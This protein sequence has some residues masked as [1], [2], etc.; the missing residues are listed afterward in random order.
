MKTYLPNIALSAWGNDGSFGVEITADT[1]RPIFDTAMENGLNILDTACAYGM[2]TSE[3]VLAGFLKGLLRESY[4]VSD[5]FTPQCADP[6]SPAAMAA[7]IKMQ[8]KL[9]ELDRFDIYW[10]H[11]VWDAPIVIKQAPKFP[12]MKAS[13]G[14][15]YF[16]PSGLSRPINQTGRPCAFSFSFSSISSSAY[17]RS[18]RCSGDRPG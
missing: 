17:N 14:L 3:K 11:N 9:M 18:W 12:S 1:L 5:K 13:G 10:I 8:L 2:G 4:L 16:S 7:M 6:S 15:F